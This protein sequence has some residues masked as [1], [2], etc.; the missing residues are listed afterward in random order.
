MSYCQRLS[1]LVLS[2]VASFCEFWLQARCTGRNALCAR[3]HVPFLLLRSMIRN[4]HNDSL[5]NQID[6]LVSGSLSWKP[7]LQ[8]G[9]DNL[10]GTHREICF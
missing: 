2:G 4:N 3:G 5:S 9:N 10:I 6:S 7:N 8:Q 1:V